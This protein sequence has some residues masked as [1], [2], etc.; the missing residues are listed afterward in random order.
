MSSSNLFRPLKL[1]KIELKH[2][3]VMAPLTRLFTDEEHVRSPVAVEHYAQRASGG[4]LVIAEATVVSL[5]LGGGKYTPGIW[6]RAQIAQWKEITDAV[7]ANGAHMFLS[8]DSLEPLADAS[9]SADKRERQAS[10]SSG[11][12]S[13]S[14][15]DSPS[16]SPPS[17][18]NEEEIKSTTRAFV[19]AARNAIAAGFDGVEVGA[20]GYFIYQ[21][22]H[23]HTSKYGGH[24]ENRIRFALEVTVAIA[25]A[26]GAERVG[27]R[28]SP[29]SA[30]RLS[31][32]APEFASLTQQLKG[33][34]LAY[35]HIIK[36]H[37]ITNIECDTYEGIKPFLAV[38]GQSSPVLIAGDFTPES[39]RSALDTEY[40]NSD[41]ALVFGQQF[42][43]LQEAK[44]PVDD[45][46]GFEISEL[47]SLNASF[48]TG[49]V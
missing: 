27:F 44:L 15:C 11:F 38:W 45:P 47:R 5:E 18:I 21:S 26:I 24:A 16:E 30:F 2:R 12:S 36:S 25:D 28:M 29:S 32:L 49:F 42:L 43:A 37:A 6:T 13:L 1:G 17:T 8:I 31:S 34:N 3:V 4:G 46:L 41:V 7:H 40:P 20:N 22:L 19:Q 9:L 48:Y 10:E 14:R 33:L 39:A 23:R 35:I